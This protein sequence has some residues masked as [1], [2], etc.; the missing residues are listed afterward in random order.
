[1]GIFYCLIIDINNIVETVVD[2]K[3][4]VNKLENFVKRSGIN[5]YYYVSSVFD[6]RKSEYTRFGVYK[7]EGEEFVII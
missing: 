6:E 7:Y 5:F 3:D 1:M 2:I 4:I